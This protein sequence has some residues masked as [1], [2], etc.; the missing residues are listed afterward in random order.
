MFVMDKDGKTCLNTKNNDFDQRAK[1]AFP[2]KNAQH[3]S[4]SRFNLWILAY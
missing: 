1:H 2:G 3:S 4:I